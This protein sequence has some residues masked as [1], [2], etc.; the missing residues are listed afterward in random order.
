M[1]SGRKAEASDGLLELL[2]GCREDPLPS[3]KTRLSTLCSSFI[4]AYLAKRGVGNENA[5]GFHAEFALY[6][7]QLGCSLYYRLLESILASEAKL[8]SDKG[9][10]TEVLLDDAFN[11]AL[12]AAAMEIV[13]FSFNSAHRFPWILE[14]LGL[15]GYHFFKGRKNGN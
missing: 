6:R 2:V 12:F 10:L 11:S 8:R 1:L 3:M 9:E 14:A 15:A 4:S 5:P 7:S 13:L